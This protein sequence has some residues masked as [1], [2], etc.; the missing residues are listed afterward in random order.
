MP[1]K[2]NTLEY[3][4]WIKT[5]GYERWKI[6]MKIGAQKRINNPEW[7]RKQQEGITKKTQDPEWKHNIK[8]GAIKRS[9]DPEWIR[10]HNEFTKNSEWLQK[11]KK[12][13]QHIS[14]NRSND[15][16]KDPEWIYKQKIGTQKRSLNP[17]WIK[18]NKKH[19][20]K[21][22]QEPEYKYKN[23]EGKIGGFWYGAVQY[24][25]KPKYCELW[26]RDLWNRIDA[27][28]DYK[29]TLS[30]LTK[31]DNGNRALS[32]HHVYWQ[33]KACCEWD[34]DKQGYFA[35][36]NIGTNWKPNWFKHYVNGDPNKFV[37]LTS[38]EH[39]MISKDKLKWIRI[40]EDIIEQ[41]GGK[42]YLTKEE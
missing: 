9:Q 27:F 31:E 8:I 23:K 4:A 14:K 3:E 18:K 41:H 17:E 40:F 33:P 32:R 5:P 34:E 28:W 16:Y 35:W 21:I 19:M 6:N 7:I 2:K 20:L 13:N 37:L 25:E 26:N 36:I 22:T 15:F 12:I 29:S 39:G 11:M 30:E 10:K 1:P 24:Y 42:S 38:K